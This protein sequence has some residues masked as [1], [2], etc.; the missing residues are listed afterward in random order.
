MTG[1]GALPAPASAMTHAPLPPPAPTLPVPTPTLPP[2]RQRVAAALPELLLGLQFLLGHWRLYL[3]GVGPDFFAPLLQAELLAIVA[4]LFMGVVGL[5]PALDAEQARGRRLLFW[6]I[7][8]FF[9]LVTPSLVAAAFFVGVMAAINVG[10]LLGRRSP[11]ATVQLGARIGVAFLV[12]FASLN[13]AGMPEAVDDWRATSPTYTSGA[14]YFLVLAGLEL[15]GFYARL[16]RRWA[17]ATAS[18]PTPEA[19]QLPEDLQRGFA[20]IGRA[21]GRLQARLAAWRRG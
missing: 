3:P 17:A 18:Q 19:R 15:H 5:T 16:A 10:T 4:T 14:L 8:A 12:L 9:L 11:G 7:F 13:I 6:G 21:A 2:L 1:S 20:V